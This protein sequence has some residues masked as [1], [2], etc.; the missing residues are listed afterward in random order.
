[1]KNMSYFF[2][3]FSFC[4]I[5]CNTNEILDKENVKSIEAFQ[6]DNHISTFFLAVDSLNNSYAQ[7]K[8][9]GLEK[10]GGKFLSAVIDYTVGAV[11]GAAT[12]PAGGAVIGTAASWA[13]D[14]NL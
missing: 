10:W 3:L 8:T 2:V 11:A 14:E 13:Y 6:E 1:M 4:T 5:S 12:T 9:R 7:Y